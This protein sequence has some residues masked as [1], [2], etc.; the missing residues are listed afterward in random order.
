MAAPRRGPRRRSRLLN[1]VE[2]QHGPESSWEAIKRIRHAWVNVEA[3]RKTG[4]VG[5]VERQETQLSAETH[6]AIPGAES[7][8]GQ[9]WR[10]GFAIPLLTA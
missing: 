3:L 2:V 4:S 7:R 5:R 6:D 1:P 8:G 9:G 10:L